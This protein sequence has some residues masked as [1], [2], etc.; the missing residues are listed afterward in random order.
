MKENT[1]DQIPPL[2]NE[3]AGDG[4]HAG[5]REDVSVKHTQLQPV[6]RLLQL[7]DHFMDKLKVALAVAD[8]GIKHLRST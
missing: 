6:I 3:L 7:P 1:C 2:L 5:A 8:E 4:P